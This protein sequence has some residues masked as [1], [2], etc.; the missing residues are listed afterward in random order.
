MKIKNL[1]SGQVFYFETF[2]N[3]I[4]TLVDEQGNVL[5]AVK[6]YKTK[7]QATALLKKNHYSIELSH[8]VEEGE[9]VKSFEA[10]V[11]SPF[12]KKIEH[13]ATKDNGDAM[14]QFTS[15]LAKM[16]E[17]DAKIERVVNESLDE[18]MILFKDELVSFVEE[19]KPQGKEITIIPL[20]GSPNNIGIQHQA[21][22]KLLGVVGQR[23]NV[24]MVGPAG[25]GK[26]VGAEKVAQALG[27]EY[28]SISVGAQTTKTE[29]FGYMDATG[30]Y[31]KT[32]FR[33]AF[34][35]GGVF[36]LDE[37][38]A[39]NANV[40]T[41]INQALANGV[42][43]FPDGMIKKHSDFVLIATANT[44]GQGANR[45]YVGR[46]QLDAAT[47]DRFAV[48]E[49]QY[50]ENLEDSLVSN[51]E[52]L[53]EVRRVRKIVSERKIRQVIS[54]R[55][56]IVGA[57]LLAAGISEDDVKEMILF[58]GMNETEKQLCK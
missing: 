19:M 16:I 15:A 7:E 31:V 21:F 26:T 57:K 51:K 47:L 36:L 37:M 6:S 44:W 3:A 11:K 27:L 12:E 55:A 23:V 14:S 18:R 49:W 56:S 43:A 1:K 41:S 54:P 39:G 25:S 5:H 42:T 45:E 4:R 46:N 33:D 53:E 22:P 20:V 24:L 58:K 29:F 28:R 30:R 9:Q 52:W 34:E 35:F 2:D 32:L 13:E 10:P 48:I 17:V 38:D 50:D 40:L 8:V